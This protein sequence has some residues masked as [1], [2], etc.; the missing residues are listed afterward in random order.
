MAEEA[1]MSVAEATT[2]EAGGR[3]PFAGLPGGSEGWLAQVVVFAAR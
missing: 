2:G 3:T 1:E